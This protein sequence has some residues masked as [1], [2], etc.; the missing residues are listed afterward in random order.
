MVFVVDNRSVFVC[1]M[2]IRLCLNVHCVA[3][4][5]YL[6]YEHTENDKMNIHIFRSELSYEFRCAH[7]NSVHLVCPNGT[8]A[9][10]KT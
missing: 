9:V 6:R 4:P 8:V 2:Y 3:L 1:I 7:F 5:S 10:E